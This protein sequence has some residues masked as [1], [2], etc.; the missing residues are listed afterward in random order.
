MHF[1]KVKQPNFTDAGNPWS[2]KKPT[3]M[4]PII[5]KKHRDENMSSYYPPLLTEI[6][7]SIY[8][9]NCKRK[10]LQRDLTLLPCKL[11]KAAAYAN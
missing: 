6:N 10:F 7:L 5:T 4:N 1:N 8:K 3:L 11:N 9:T 2:F